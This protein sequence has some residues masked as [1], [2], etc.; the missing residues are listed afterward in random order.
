MPHSDIHGST[1]ARGSPWLFAACHVFHRLLVPRHPPNALLLLEIMDHPRRRD[2][3]PTMHRRYSHP[4]Y[5]ADSIHSAYTCSAPAITTEAATAPLNTCAAITMVGFPY[6]TPARSVAV[7]DARP[8]THQNLIYNS[9]NRQ[10]KVAPRPTY[11]VTASPWAKPVTPISISSLR[12]E[13]LMPLNTKPQ[14]N[15]GKP[16]I[17]RQSSTG[18]P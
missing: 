12:R 4:Q 17:G 3:P 9:M 18:S 11:N 1:P 14:P 10:P 16:G 5:T 6:G 7:I 8:E 13:C 2:G 15:S